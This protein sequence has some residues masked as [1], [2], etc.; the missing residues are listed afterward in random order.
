MPE[1]QLFVCD[2]SQATLGNVNIK[3]I[4][5]NAYNI[6]LSDILYLAHRS[7]KNGAVPFLGFFAVDV[8]YHRPT[9]GLTIQKPSFVLV[10]LF[11]CESIKNV[12][13]Y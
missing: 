6:A 13:I 12:S 2:S 7:L 4:L 8:E 10:L 3:H 1:S 5:S 9:H 11:L